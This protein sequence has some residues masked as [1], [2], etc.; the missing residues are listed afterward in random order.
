MGTMLTQTIT[1]VDT[2]LYT[3]ICTCMCV[4]I[5]IYTHFFLVV[6]LQEVS[7]SGT[8]WAKDSTLWSLKGL[9]VPCTEPLLARLCG[10]EGRASNPKPLNP[11]PLNPKPLNP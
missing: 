9:K 1:D 10:P 2:E 8:P 3:C 11:K 4:Y 5:Y 6:R 7:T